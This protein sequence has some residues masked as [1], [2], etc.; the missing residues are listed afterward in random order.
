[1]GV[2]GDEGEAGGVCLCTADC[3][4]D[5]ELGRSAAGLDPILRFLRRGPKVLGE[6]ERG[7]DVADPPDDDERSDRNEDE[8]L[9]GDSVPGAVVPS[10]PL[11][12]SNPSSSSSS[13]SSNSAPLFSSILS[14]DV[15][16]NM[17]MFPYSFSWFRLVSWYVA[18]V[19]PRFCCFVKWFNRYTEFESGVRSFLRRKRNGC[20]WIVDG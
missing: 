18:P 6:A 14:S 8:E 5:G 7:C 1:M 15:R 17:L 16:R 12:S 20:N 13:S 10:F 3:I 2:S 11:V 19:I 9:H 4:L